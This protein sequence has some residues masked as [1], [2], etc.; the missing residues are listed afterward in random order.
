MKIME[1]NGR[2]MKNGTQKRHI[3]VEWHVQ[4]ISYRLLSDPNGPINRI[5]SFFP[6]ILVVQRARSIRGNE[7]RSEKDPGGRRG[8]VNLPPR[9]LFWRFWR[10]GG[11]LVQGLYTPRGQMIRRIMS[12]TMW[13]RQITTLRDS[14]IN[15][16]FKESC[17]QELLL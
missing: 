2:K 3:D 8:R 12:S 7:Q 5:Y 15:R 11:L 1:D 13:L 16:H 6:H 4:C 10:F 9:S 17:I 14:S